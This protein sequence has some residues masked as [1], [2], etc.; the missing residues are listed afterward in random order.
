MVDVS[1]PE[2]YRLQM[3][4]RDGKG[5]VLSP[6]RDNL[7]E[8]P[9][10]PQPGSAEFAT[11]PYSRMRSHMLQL[12]THD[13]SEVCSGGTFEDWAANL[14]LK[15]PHMHRKTQGQWKRNQPIQPSSWF[16]LHA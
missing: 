5:V 16:G 6:A 8:M 4:C 14:R 12:L 15:R 9:N 3:S 2:A 7:D 13:T 11:S 1:C 10:V